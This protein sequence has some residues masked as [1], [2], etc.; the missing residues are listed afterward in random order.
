MESAQDFIRH[1]TG[2]KDL[3]R[4][5]AEKATEGIMSG[6]WSG[7]QIGA[8]LTAMNMKGE[9][10]EEIVGSATV[11]RAKA[12]NKSVKRR[13]L[14]D[15]VGSGGDGLQTINVSTLAG[16]VVAGAGVGVA[17]HGNRA[18]SG[19]CGSADILEGLGV[20]IEISPSD[21]V[22]SIDHNGFAFLFAPHFHES[23]KYAV[24][25]RREIGI[26]TIFNYLGPL[27]NPVGVEYHL[28]GVSDRPNTALFTEVLIGLG[29]P[30]SIVAHG[31]DG[32]DEITTT[33]ET[34]IVEQIEGAIREY[35][36][37]PEEF[38]L[39]RVNLADLTIPDKKTAIALA[40]AFLKGEAPRQHEDLVLFNAAAGLYVANAAKD[41]A[42][43]LDI[44]RESLR[45]GAATGMLA[46]LTEYTAARKLMP[47]G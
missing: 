2:G 38:G 40:K 3:S 29:C 35:S 18:M 30:H 44:A 8:Y 11:M 9:N 7:A 17:K 21:A 34:H 26:P 16:L 46:K 37:T 19:M 47:A 27:T 6:A 4:K 15:I 23:M 22:D 45:S 42:E 5:E 14:L 32:M 12:F 41:I 39:P 31:A 10:R 13:P 28:I 33:G 25:P 43:G 20:T 36:L 24:G 1:L